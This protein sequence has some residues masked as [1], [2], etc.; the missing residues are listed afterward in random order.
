[1]RTLHE[2]LTSKGKIE[3]GKVDI[4]GDR[5]D[6][7]TPPT[8]P[9]KEH[10]DKPYF[11]SNGKG[12][13]STNKGLGDQGDKAL[14]YEPD[15][16]KDSKKPADIPTVPEQF[17]QYELVP[18]V[19]E[20]LGRNPYF[21]ENLVLDLQRKGI[22]GVLV[23]EL[24]EHRETYKHITQ[25][26]EHKGGDQIHRKLSKALE[27]VSPAYS[28]QTEDDDLEETGLDDVEVDDDTMDMDIEEPDTVGEEDLEFDD[29]E[30]L[31]DLN[32]MGNG[33]TDPNLKNP[34]PMPTFQQ[35]MMSRR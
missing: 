4:H 32:G 6:P 22:L 7:M 15:I 13:K 2:Y 33:Q 5:T 3:S 16:G 21:A 24:M 26:I 19:T 27:E 9:P 18:L 25:L 8:K 17:A 1:M 12:E 29:T 35:A 20:S 10:G 28:S 31:G 14:K 11:N 30:E 23:G 34:R